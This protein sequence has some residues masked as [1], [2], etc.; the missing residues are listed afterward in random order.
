MALGAITI[1]ARSLTTAEFGTVVFLH[2]VVLFLTETATFDSWLLVV[3]E[4]SHAL[5]SGCRDRF[6]RTLRFSIALDALAAVLAFGLAGAV[7][8]LL[9]SD[10]GALEG[11]STGLALA[12]FSLVL[13]RQTSASHGVLRVFSRYDLLAVS[14]L[15]KPSLRL[16]GSFT[17][18]AMGA[19]LG[20]FLATWFAA[21][22]GTYLLTISLALREL[23]RRGLLGEVFSAPP[24]LKAPVEGAWSF[25]GL[26][27]LSSGLDA[28]TRK[29]PLLLVG[30]FAG[31]AAAG[32]FKIAEEVA[33]L[34]SKSVK[35]VDRVIFPAFAAYDATGEAK[36]SR[37]LMAK[38]A[39]SFA[40]A[41]GLLATGL[42]LT[43]EPVMQFLFSAPYGDAAMT[44]AVLV[45]AGTMTAVASPILSAR[46]AQG[47]LKAPV[48]LK[49]AGLVVMV[50]AFLPLTRLYG[51]TGSAAA[52]LSGTLLVAIGAA[53]TMPARPRG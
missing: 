46:T 12:Y 27:N 21:S 35:T 8:L 37:S 39:L 30:L 10:M 13:F 17:A 41:G 25:T 14:T 5:V 29:L 32:L 22:A 11:V 31:P 38:T 6:A 44:A 49:L 3:R 26:T 7:L 40:A 16:V 50:A 48:F 18:A 15:L 20:G 23:H 28:G 1:A 47:K 51:H 24:S 19:G 34:L 42:A 9:P 2:G 4:G 33:S 45:A 43:G 53:L 36:A 52:V